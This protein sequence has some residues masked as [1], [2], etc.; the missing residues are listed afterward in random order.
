MTTLGLCCFVKATWCC[1]K[2][3]NQVCHTQWWCCERPLIPRRSPP[4]NTMQQ[5][6]F[7]TVAHSALPP[8]VWKKKPTNDRQGLQAA[9]PNPSPVVSPVG[10]DDAFN[11]RCSPSSSEIDQDRFPSKRRL[12]WTAKECDDVAFEKSA[13]ASVAVSAAAE[14]ISLP[15]QQIKR[16]EDP[17]KLGAVACSERLW[18]GG[19]NYVSELSID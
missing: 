7:T 18:V 19:L 11:D 2:H 5:Q 6:S 9:D 4:I 3:I 1:D 16:K 13:A 15:R 14:P 8:R 10:V 12:Q 17:S